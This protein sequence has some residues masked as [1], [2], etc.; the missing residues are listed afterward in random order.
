MTTK[1]DQRARAKVLVAAGIRSGTPGAARLGAWLATVRI[2]RN[3]SR[4]EAAKK[5]GVSSN[6]YGGWEIGTGV[7]GERSMAGLRRWLGKP[8]SAEMDEVIQEL[9]ATEKLTPAQAREAVGLPPRSDLG[10]DGVSVQPEPKAARRRPA[11]AARDADA[12]TVAGADE[13]LLEALIGSSLS[14]RSKA[15]LS[16]AVVALLAGI[17]VE[18]EVR[19]RV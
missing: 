14:A 7:P 2:Q 17:D 8:L 11:R 18:V 4:G 5:I 19:A 16:A 12:A 1:I 15:L 13:A 9:G 3:E 10:P 6:V